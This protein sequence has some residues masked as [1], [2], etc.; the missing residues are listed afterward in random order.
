M[1]LLLS[2]EEHI[3]SC[4]HSI[5]EVSRSFD[6]DVRLLYNLYNTV[7][8]DQFVKVFDDSEVHKGL[9]HYANNPFRVIDPEFKA[10]LMEFLTQYD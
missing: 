7:S 8:F 2:D 4:I 5:K 3:Q 9:P 10:I 6:E 1:I